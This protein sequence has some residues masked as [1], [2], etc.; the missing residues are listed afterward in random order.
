MGQVFGRT[1][2]FLSTVLNAL[3]FVCRRLTPLAGICMLVLGVSSTSLSAQSGATGAITIIQNTLPQDPQDFAFTVT[4]GLTSAAFTLDND[5][6]GTLPNTQVLTDLPVGSYTITQPSVAGFTNFIACT[7]DVTGQTVGSNT[8]ISN[9]ATVEIPAADHNITC[10]FT[11]SYIATFT[12]AFSPATIEAGGTS[13]LTYTIENL[14]IYQ[15]ANFEFTDTFTNITVASPSNAISTCVPQFFSGTYPI[16]TATPGSNVI[17]HSSGYRAPGYSCTI[18]VDVT[19]TTVGE[20]ISTS[21]DLATNRGNSGAAT[22]TLTVLEATSP[23]ATIS[24]A[25][26]GTVTAPFPISIDFDEEVTGF[27]ETDLVVSGATVSDFATTDNTTFTATLTPTTDGTV[28]VDI[29]AAVAQDLVGNDNVAA[30]QFSIGADIT[31]PVLTIVGATT[32]QTTDFQITINPSEN[33]NDLLLSD[34]VV[35]NA[36]P[37]NLSAS[38]GTSFTVDITNPVLGTTVD[39]TI[40]AGAVTDDAGQPNA[41]AANYQ[42]SAGSPVTEFENKED[43]VIDLVQDDVRRHLIN[44]INVNQKMMGN[45]LDRFIRQ[46]EGDV[47]TQDA[48]FDIDGTAELSGLAFATKGDFFGLKNLNNGATRFV[49]GQFDLNV[50]EDGS[51]TGQLSARAVWERPLSNTANI[52][53]FVGG[54]IGKSDISSSFTGDSKTLGILGGVYG[55]KQFGD[56]L[57]GTAYA[58]IG[59]SWSDIA[60]T[61]G[62]LSLDGDYGSASFYVGTE[63]AGTLDLSETVELRPNFTLD[64]AY[65][66]I[67]AVGFD[68]SSFGITAPVISDI[69]SVSI[70][71]GS[72]APEVIISLGQQSTG[73]ANLRFEPSLICRLQTGRVDS[74]G[75]GGGVALGFEI[76]SADGLRHITAGYE[77][78]DVDGTQ[79][80][81][82]NLS[83]EVEW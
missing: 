1:N 16:V 10:L 20:H 67:G 80:E 77:Y 49:M 4:G 69:G 81:S 13:R 50:D 63:L 55:L 61:D 78:T 47:A 70:L 19:S 32:P 14:G 28:T 3:A 58:G 64:Y 62:V 30:A 41:V 68:A 8:G 39:V 43:D 38:T 17:A 9:A 6:D 72:L 22:A 23:T 27:T 53:Y 45:A 71:E 31:A 52:G 46:R 11:N 42:V 21:S 36:T 56:A 15:A 65:A 7:S 60:I 33:I 12:K 5:A 26:S 66:Q 34:I 73:D 40:A 51:T 82:M 57:Y 48:A 59:Y 37:A 18:S 54:H 24:S 79:Q 29:A 75:C 74:S 83:I 35:T 44:Q 2:R 25:S 76:T